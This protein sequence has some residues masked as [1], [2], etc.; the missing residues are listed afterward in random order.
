MALCRNSQPPPSSAVPAATASAL[1]PADRVEPIDVVRGMALFGVLIVNLI[2]EFRVSIFL[3][4]LRPPLAQ[5]SADRLVERIVTLGFES[6][7]FCLFSLLFGVGLAIQFERLSRQGHPIYWLFRRL[8][9]LLALALIHLLFIWNGD[10]L[11]EYAV[12]GL[13]VLPFL[14]LDSPALLIAALAMLAIHAV[15]PTLLYSIPWPDEGTLQQHVASAHQVYATGTLLAIWRFSVHEL[16]L[17]GLLHL[18]VLPRTVGLFLLGAY[19]WR[20]GVLRRLDEFKR[21]WIAAAVVATAAGAA[22]MALDLNGLLA[23]L[24]VFQTFLMNLAPVVLAL[25]YGAGIL[26]MTQFPA[27]ARRLGAF[28]PIGRMAFTNYLMQSVV[29]GF[30]F[31]SWG[32]GLFGQMQ[33]MAALALGV[34]VFALQMLFSTWWLKRYRYGP[35]EWLWRTLMYGSAQPMRQ[36]SP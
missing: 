6:K 35:V 34:A 31:F 9:V 33:P 25:G 12:A 19:L 17:V 5:G 14:L 8:A 26:A 36:A 1:A 15:G 2:T 23:P 3:Q 27:A 24:G 29:F 10:I 21:Q 16:P 11:T 20:T 22:L 32:L 13:I 18:F 28:A 7:A 4:F 30:I